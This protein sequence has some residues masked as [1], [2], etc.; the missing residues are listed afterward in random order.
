MPLSS[1][2]F[3]GYSVSEIFLNRP[4]H[5][6]FD[7]FDRIKQKGKEQAM[8]TSGQVSI[9]AT[10]ILRRED[11][12][13]LLDAL[14]VQGYRTIGPTLS[15][16]TIVY[17]EVTSVADL[18]MG[19]TDEQGP[20]TYRLRRR[21]DDALFGYIP[22]AHSWKPWLRPPLQRLW[23]ARRTDDGFEIIPDKKEAPRYAFIGVRACELHAIQIQ[24]Q[25]FTGGA[26]VDQTYNARR[27]QAFILAMNCTEA[28][29]TCFCAS[30]GTGPQ[31]DAGY[32]LAMT[33]IVT[34][35]VHHFVVDIGSKAG[36]QVM[37]VVPHRTAL[38]R[39]IEM[40]QCEI[41]GAAE[42]MG[43]K[44]NANGVKELL[45]R[46]LEHPHWDDVA[47]R[48]LS[49]ANCTLVCP[50]CFCSTVEDV[51]D[52]AGQEAERWRRT[53]SCF[54][55]DFSYIHGGSV[56]SSSKSRYRQW[57]TH[58]LASWVDQ[59]GTL[60]CVGCGRC[61]TWCPVGIDLTQE[62]A[63]IRAAEQKVEAG[64]VRQVMGD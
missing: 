58:K 6:N 1:R 59:F 64:G 7:V 17:D 53:D 54:S 31:A 33:E 38:G 14:H 2:R 50:T 57:L 16:G 27:E 62:V 23:R 10:V 25:V 22:G 45:Y 24:D 21:G 12:Q 39:E 5:P 15:E 26:Y 28:G 37:S 9:G 8:Q 18:P 34:G 56:R 19:W 3:F 35:G 29:E 44:L 43:R 47:A 36:A 20:G 42:H 61:I 51:T 11:F 55:L 41:A 63:T 52:L 48:C 46:N 4:V 40:A 30:L 13:Q 32:D 49:C 60:G